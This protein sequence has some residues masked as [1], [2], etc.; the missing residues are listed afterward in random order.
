MRKNTRAEHRVIFKSVAK[1]YSCKPARHCGLIANGAVKRIN[2][3]V[4]KGPLDMKPV[5]RAGPVSYEEF[6][7]G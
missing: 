2:T 6:Q 3:C 1:H 4:C 5:D 7:P